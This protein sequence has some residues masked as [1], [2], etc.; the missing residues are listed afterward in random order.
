[1]K[2]G[3]RKNLR[4]EAKCRKKSSKLWGDW[5]KFAGKAAKLK[6]V[7]VIA[8]LSYYP[9]ERTGKAATNAMVA[10]AKLGRTHPQKKFILVD[11]IKEPE[12]DKSRRI[13]EK[14]TLNLKFL[15]SLKAET[16]RQLIQGMINTE[17]PHAKNLQKR[18][19]LFFATHLF[20]TS[21][22]VPVPSAS[23]SEIC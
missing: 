15:C 10:I 21:C 18:N 22:A 19:N 20:R 11:N 6:D 2:G 16:K 1:M 5:T 23:F 8:F 12:R 4:A 3:N 9:M 14:T 13:I 7:D 17:S